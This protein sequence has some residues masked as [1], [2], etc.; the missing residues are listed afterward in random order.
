METFRRDGEN[1]TA[2]ISPD[3]CVREHVNLTIVRK[4]LAVTDGNFEVTDDKGNIMFRVTEKL[5]S[6][7]NRHVLLDAGGTPIVTFSKK[8]HNLGFS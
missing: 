3:F 2:V 5:L 6:I 8:V 1:L 4:L 7:H